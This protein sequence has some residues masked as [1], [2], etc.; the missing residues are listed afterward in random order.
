MMSGILR[1][2]ISEMSVLVVDDDDSVR[3]IIMSVLKDD[4]YRVDGRSNPIEALEQVDISKVD[5]VITDIVMPKMTGIEFLEKLKSIK[6]EIN[7]IVMTSFSSKEHAIAALKHDAYDFLEKPF[8]DLNVVSAVARKVFD[9][10]NLQQQKEK[11]VSA[12]RNKNLQLTDFSKKL[13]KVAITDALTGLYNRRFFQI[14]L[15]KEFKRAHRYQRELSLMFIDV[16]HFKLFNDKNGHIKGDKALKGI[17]ELIRRSS[18]EHDI[19]ARYGGEEFVLL[20]PETG[21]SK[22]FLCADKLRKLVASA[23]FRHDNKTDKMTVSIGVASISNCMDYD[24]MLDRAD[25]ALYIAK[26]SG[27]NQVCKDKGKEK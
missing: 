20:M 26:Q 7:V 18:R 17:A 22:A 19:A 25:Q 14:S 24:E 15:A 27:R 1:K 21:E 10:V 16:D 9:T 6:P 2:K 8:S 13:H 12:L 3:E 5:L 11:L 4:G 23:N